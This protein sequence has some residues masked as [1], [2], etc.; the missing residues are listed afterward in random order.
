MLRKIVVKTESIEMSMSVQE[1][2]EHVKNKLPI[3]LAY[4]FH[5]ESIENFI[6][7][8]NGIESERTRQRV[9]CMLIEYL[10][11]ILEMDISKSNQQMT[12]KNNYVQ[13]ILKIGMIYS[14]E[15]GFIGKPSFTISI[16]I[17][18]LFLIIGYLYLNTFVLIVCSG[19]WIYWFV[20]S[21]IKVKGRKYY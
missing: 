1:K 4:N 7:H 20:W 21:L 6:L 14:D 18:L 10:N 17:L 19:V 16:G 13:T 11:G 15:V 12:Y 9:L 8:L 3:N 2:L 5:I